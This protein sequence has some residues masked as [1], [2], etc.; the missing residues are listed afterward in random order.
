MGGD[1]KFHHPQ[2]LK[3][4]PDFQESGEIRVNN[5]IPAPT[6]GD[7]N[8]IGVCWI[9]QLPTKFL[10]LVSAQRYSHNVKVTR[11]NQISDN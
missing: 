4:N 10:G 2:I 7:I 1:I 8:R 11:Q 5:E 3:K 6:G 9:S